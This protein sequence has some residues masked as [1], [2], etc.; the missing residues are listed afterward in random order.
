MVRA[1][2]AMHDPGSPAP[3]ASKGSPGDEEQLEA[4]REARKPTRATVAKGIKARMRSIFALDAPIL[5]AELQDGPVQLD[6]FGH[7]M[8]AQAP[9]KLPRPWPGG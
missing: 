5:K 6:C 2:L 3:E 8:Q 1:W 4:D 7:E 9:A